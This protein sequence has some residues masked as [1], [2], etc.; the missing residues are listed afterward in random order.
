MSFESVT[1]VVFAIFLALYDNT[2]VQG[3]G[4]DPLATVLPELIDVLRVAHPDGNID[5]S[6]K[7]SSALIAFLFFCF[8]LF[9][10]YE[11]F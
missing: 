10:S 6:I 9:P 11:H 2:L 1:A 3:P 5:R 4:L 8:Q 7:L